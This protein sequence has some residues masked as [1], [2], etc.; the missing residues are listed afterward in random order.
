MWHAVENLRFAREANDNGLS[1]HR[2]SP[3][4]M[5][6]RIL[7]ITLPILNRFSKYF[8]C[9]KDEEISNKTSTKFPT[10]MWME[11]SWGSVSGRGRRK[12]C[13]SAECAVYVHYF[14]NIR[15]RVPQSNRLIL[16]GGEH[17]TASSSNN[18]LRLS[19]D[20]NL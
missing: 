13:F 11:L 18:K 8:H 20:P 6:C 16:Y 14:K 17:G 1:P 5:C 12:T 4:K 15:Q 7:A 10:L 3:E 19:N 9:E 2:Y